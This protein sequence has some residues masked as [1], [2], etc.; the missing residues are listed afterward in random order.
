MQ[1]RNTLQ[2]GEFFERWQGPAARNRWR[3]R[4]GTPVKSPPPQFLLP[5]TP[6]QLPLPQFRLPHVPIIA[7]AKSP[8][9][10]LMLLPAREG[11]AAASP[12]DLPPPVKPPL[13][14][15]G[16]GPDVRYREETCKPAVEPSNP[17][18]H[19]GG[20]PLSEV[21]VGS[22]CNGTVTNSG[23]YGISV[24][25]GAVEDGWVELPWGLT[26]FP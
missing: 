15:W 6:S 18:K 25:F 11:R 10:Q 16:R 9:S 20:T 17:W 13:R 7:P 2:D 1:F 23:M 3:S 8:P 22:L 19:S 14:R 4:F 5:P 24:N 21:R 12:G 26:Q